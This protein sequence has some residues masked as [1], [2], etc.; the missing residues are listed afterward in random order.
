VKY[1]II[2]ENNRFSL[3]LFALL[4]ML[5]SFVFISFFKIPTVS[6]G[7]QPVDIKSDIKKMTEKKILK[8]MTPKK[9]VEEFIKSLIG[10]GVLKTIE[11]EPVNGTLNVCEAIDNGLRVAITDINQQNGTFSIQVYLNNENAGSIGNIC[12]VCNKGVIQCSD[13]IN[14]IDCTTKEIVFDNNTKKIKCQPVPDEDQAANIVGLCYCTCAYCGSPIVNPFE[15]K[16]ILE[17]IGDG[18]AKAI[19]DSEKNLF[20]SSPSITDEQILEITYKEYDTTKCPDIQNATGLR[21]N[22]YIPSKDPKELASYYDNPE[23]MEKEGALELESQQRNPSSLT[24]M[25]QES[26]PSGYTITECTIEWT[27]YVESSSGSY[28]SC[29]AYPTKNN[30]VFRLCSSDNTKIDYIICEQ[31]VTG[32][33]TAGEDANCTLKAEEVCLADKDVCDYIVSDYADTGSSL[34]NNYQSCLT[35][36]GIVDDYSVCFYGETAD[37]MAVNASVGK[38]IMSGKDL[39][40]KVRYEYECKRE[41][42]NSTYTN[43]SSQDILNNAT[44][45]VTDI[46]GTSELTDYN[47]MQVTNYSGNSTSFS[48]LGD[49]GKDSSNGNCTMICE[50]KVGK[51]QPKTSYSGKVSSVEEQDNA[52]QT[53]DESKDYRVEVR[54]CFYSDVENKWMCP[55]D[56]SAGEEPIL[57][58]GNEEGDYCKCET[59]PKLGEAA[60]AA[61]IISESKTDLICSS[62]P[63][64]GVNQ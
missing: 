15:R 57:P 49:V 12:G 38:V 59:F 56:Q 51:K 11:G 2:Q 19:S 34:E 10:E 24:Y 42:D 39:Y 26:N 9:I 43:K 7:D 55:Y 31:D 14:W 62:K 29:D 25:T 44:S 5:M 6:A 17:M 30:E 46:S 58:E 64:E 21:N 36:H 22:V 53:D 61:E 16:D 40:W 47:T 1:P 48:V 45:V 60:V 4:I 23:K 20:F 50:V 63:P 35:L 3:K 33:C 8:K 28:S 27:C 41:L 13:P 37:V 18:V 52:T 32:N 54:T